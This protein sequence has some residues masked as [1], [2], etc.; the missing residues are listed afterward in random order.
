MNKLYDAY[1]QVLLKVEKPSRYS[2]GEYNSFK[3]FDEGARFCLLFPDVYEV[4]ISNL[5]NKIIYNYLNEKKG[6]SCERAYA[7]WIDMAAEL[8]NSG[9][10]LFS[11]DSRTPLCDFDALGVSLSYEMSYTNM[12]LM[13]DLGKIPLLAKDR[14]ERN[15][16]V[17]AGGICVVNPQ[18]IK[19]FIDFTVLGEGEVNLTPVLDLIKKYKD[20]KWTKL[21]LLKKID[22]LSFT[23]VPSLHKEIYENGKFV[24]YENNKTV[25]K[26]IVKD[27]DKVFFPTKQIVP[28]IQAVFDRSV[29]EVFRGCPRGCR[30]CQ[31]GFCYRPIRGKSVETLVQNAV[32]CVKN[33]GFDELSLN[34]LSTGDFPKIE[35][36]IQEIS[37][38]TIVHGV[39]LSLPSLRLDS[40]A[41]KKTE[42]I[43]KNGSLTFAPEAGSQ[44]LRDVINK[45]ISQ[46]DF[47]HALKEAY[48]VGYKNVKL[49]F[50]I[51][52]PTETDEDVLGIFELC[53]LAKEV[54]REVTRRKDVSISASVANF[55]PKPFT[56]FQYCKQ[57]SFSEFD[58][59]HKLLKDAFYKSGFKLSY[60][61]SYISKLEGAFALS[62]SVMNRVLLS[63]YKNG[64]CFDG[65]NEKFNREA[66]EKAFDE[67]GLNLDEMSK[68]YSTLDLLPWYNI[69]V[70][71]DEKFFIKEYEKSI[72]G[73]K[74]GG[75][76]DKCLACGSNRLGECKKCW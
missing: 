46:D 43:K 28:N 58:R 41:S 4:A 16:I 6:Y 51:G 8:R 3:K 11:L 64:A 21:E 55:V 9:L 10:P 42:G 31:A 74:T 39:K 40:F 22:E 76:L 27:L 7:P 18:P 69:D 34:S 63:S 75:C 23:F 5:G 52:L 48:S 45:S 54:Y 26:A 68:G 72:L 44:R 38:K 19:D 73:E 61:D 47:I 56:P 1:E 24:G 2:G 62:G 66:W 35:Q 13:L 36:T 17:F 67:N 59:K 49:Y 30:F 20:E 57:D 71:V 15:P 12:L 50:M 70:G 14:D 32:D 60:H 37:D 53:K 29:L 25:K 65:W 33:T